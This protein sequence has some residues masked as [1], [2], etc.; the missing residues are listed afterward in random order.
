MK[1]LLRRPFFFIMLF[2]SLTHTEIQKLE[3]LLKEIG[4]PYE[5]H[6]NGEKLDS[7]QPRTGANV[8]EVEIA[9]D[10]LKQI[11]AKFH[12]RLERF[13]IFTQVDMPEE[14]I[15]AFEEVKEA[16]VTEKKTGVQRWL[17]WQAVVLMA[18]AAA[19]IF[20]RLK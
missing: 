1:G 16:P 15:S 10:D 6:V 9:D 3:P 2:T 5:I 7:K 4:V 20:K 14:F 17:S 18:L 13:G 11:P 8:F 12:D 19:Y